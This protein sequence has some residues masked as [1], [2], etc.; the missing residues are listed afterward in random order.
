MK[1]M[2]WKNELVMGGYDEY[3]QTENGHQFMVKLIFGYKTVG[4]YISNSLC[5]LLAH[6]N[7]RKCLR[8]A[9]RQLYSHSNSRKWIRYASR[10][11]YSITVVCT[12]LVACMAFAFVKTQSAQGLKITNHYRMK[13]SSIG[14]GKIQIYT[15]QSNPHQ[16]SRMLISGVVR[17]EGAFILNWWMFIVDLLGCYRQTLLRRK[18]YELVKGLL[19]LGLASESCEELKE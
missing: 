16:N 18:D 14:S 7:L 13:D 19:E 15:T 4:L 3:Y 8:H 5:R 12:K 1:L 10:Q 17:H 6:S 2:K 11:L 9:S